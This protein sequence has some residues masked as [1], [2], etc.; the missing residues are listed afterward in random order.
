VS[1]PHTRGDRR[2]LL[3]WGPTC[4]PDP[5]EIARF[6][7]EQ[8]PLRVPPRRFDPVVPGLIGMPLM[9]YRVIRRLQ[10]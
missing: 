6:Q 7:R 4:P 2:V 1:R 3:A 9:G 8:P 10:D 5:R